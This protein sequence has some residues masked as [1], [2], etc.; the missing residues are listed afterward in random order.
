MLIRIGHYTEVLPYFLYLRQ[1][2][3]DL[4]ASEENKAVSMSHISG[5]KFI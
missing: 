2:C 4:S 5:N 1:K 3:L